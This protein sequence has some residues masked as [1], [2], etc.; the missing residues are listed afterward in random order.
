MNLKLVKKYSFNFLVCFLLTSVSGFSQELNEIANKMFVDMNNRDYDAI[1]DMT[2]PKVF[3]IV[4]KEQMK[5]V[6][7]STLE[8]NSEFSIEI[9]KQTPEFK[10]SEV[11]KEEKDDL[12]YAFVTYD[13]TMKMTFHKQT[14]NDESKEMMKGVMQSKGMDVTFVSD[15]SMSVLMNNRMTIIL[16]D[17]ST[18][19]KWVMI[20]YD[21]DSPLMDGIL[22]KSLLETAK[23]Y[24]QDLMLESKEKKQN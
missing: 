6:L 21:P 13:M 1:L 16:K 3:D 11:Y 17:T 22:S 19:G 18:K 9:P 2:H 20:N 4:S 15:N 23:G 8:G 7:K 10:V 12:S 14:F 24:Q 5:T